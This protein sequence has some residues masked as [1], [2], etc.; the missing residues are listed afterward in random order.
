MQPVADLGDRQ[1]L[2]DYAKVADKRL[3]TNNRPFP[4]CNTWP[5]RFHSRSK[6]TP[7]GEF[8]PHRAPDWARGGNNVLEYSIHCVLIKDAQVSVSEE[9]KF[10]GFE[11]KTGFVRLVFDDDRAVVRH[12]GLGTNRSVF[13]ISGDDAVSRKLIG[14]DFYFRKLGGYTGASVVWCVGRHESDFTDILHK[15]RGECLSEMPI[16]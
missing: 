15:A 10:E 5:A 1:A 8:T 9:I 11:L 3:G 16:R 6:T 14:P 4:G 13:G 7:R 2:S 12:P